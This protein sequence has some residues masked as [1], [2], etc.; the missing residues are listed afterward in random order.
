MALVQYAEPGGEY[1]LPWAR[2]K[3]RY[4]HEEMLR[5]GQYNI[6]KTVYVSDGAVI[7]ASSLHLGHG[8]FQDRIRVTAAGG[9]VIGDPYQ[10]LWG[11]ESALMPGTLPDV[12]PEL[13]WSPTVQHITSYFPS[14]DGAYLR[15]HWLVICRYCKRVAEYTWDET[16]ALATP[17]NTIVG[18]YV[19]HAADGSTVTVM[20]TDA[21]GLETQRVVTISPSLVTTSTADP[22]GWI[23]GDSIAERAVTGPVVATTY[24]TVDE[25]LDENG[26]HI[27][28][29]TST[30]TF[31]IRYADDNSIAAQ[32]SISGTQHQQTY[33]DGTHGAPNGFI[34][35]ETI[36]TG[37]FVGI[38]SPYITAAG[39]YWNEDV[40][41]T[42]L[43]TANATYLAAVASAA[44]SNAAYD[45]EVVSAAKAIVSGALDLMDEKKVGVPEVDE[46]RPYEG[47]VDHRNLRQAL[48]IP[49]YS[50]TQ[51]T[52]S[53][54]AS[55]TT[56][57]YDSIVR[58]TL[59]P[60]SIYGVSIGVSSP[61]VPAA[62]VPPWAVSVGDPLVFTYAPS[63]KAFTAA[64][65]IAL[66][67]AYYSKGVTPPLLLGQTAAL[68]YTGLYNISGSVLD[69]D[70][71]VTLAALGEFGALSEAEI[72]DLMERLC[73]GVITLAEL[74][75]ITYFAFRAPRPEAV[76]YR[77]AEHAHVSGSYSFTQ[78]AIS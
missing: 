41:P 52:F 65:T 49:A 29:N 37:D 70:E 18:A 26:N 32:T 34:D 24:D 15:R 31:T 66:T 44:A 75:Y 4:W 19:S 67:S 14:A 58:S 43:I 17:S 10:P 76:V 2:Q 78:P 23:D 74:A 3:L 56:L 59:I 27:Y 62:P 33:F 69:G 30:T 64:G 5:S 47:L 22:W 60:S 73:V 9:Y 39:T 55:S 16:K 12:V 21:E 68:G 25:G 38:G 71:V 28:L 8:V 54:G 42:S 77:A 36:Y 13:A 46:L 51:F 35:I 11:I 40:V 6:S 48:V 7:Y 72:A 57:A 53:K 50:A 1:L 45:A 20:D 61:A 63:T